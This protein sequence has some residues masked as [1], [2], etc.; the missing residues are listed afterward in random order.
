MTIN[1]Q[2]NLHI[3]F[4]QPS[5]RNAT[6]TLSAAALASLGG[7]SSRRGSGDAGSLIMDADSS[8]SELKVIM[9]FTA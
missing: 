7:T 4:L 8:L 6:P 2:V 5:S 9:I 3:C 1:W